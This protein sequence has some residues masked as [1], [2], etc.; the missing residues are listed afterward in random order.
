MQAFGCAISMVQ[1]VALLG[2]IGGNGK[3]RTVG[4]S[5][6]KHL[7]IPPRYATS[8]KLYCV[9]FLSNNVY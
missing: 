2:W 7:L 3:R 4:F 8:Y 6:L 1:A 5:E 9:L